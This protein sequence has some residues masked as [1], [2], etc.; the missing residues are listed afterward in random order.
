M[1]DDPSHTNP[2]RGL[3]AYYRENVIGGPSS[4]AR[5]ADSFSYADWQQ[6]RTPV[7][8]LLAARAFGVSLL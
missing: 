8:A 1:E 5:L 7:Q 2:P 6:R 3:D 4:F